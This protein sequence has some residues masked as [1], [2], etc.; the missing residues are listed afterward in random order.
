ME[1]DMPA[2]VPAPIKFTPTKDTV[3]RLDSKRARQEGRADIDFELKD[4]V[5]HPT[6]NPQ[7]DTRPYT[8]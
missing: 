2:A 8:N 7:P 5:M 1:I 4:L 3:D 6:D